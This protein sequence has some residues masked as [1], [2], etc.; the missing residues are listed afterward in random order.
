[1]LR[2]DTWWHVYLD[3][4]KQSGLA[5][6]E[7]RAATMGAALAF[8]S[9]FSLAPLLIIVIALAG[10]V[11]G[12]DAA[13]GAVVAQMAGLVGAPAAEAI[14]ALL[15]AAQ[16]SATSLFA[17]VV[18]LVMMLVGATTVLVELQDDL[19]QIWEAPRRAG[20]GLLSILRARILSLGMLLAIGFLLLV[21]LLFSGA[22]AAFGS[23]WEAY[24]PGAALILFHVSNNALS[25]GAITVLFAMLF[26]WLPN[27]TI[28]WK[29]VWVGALTTAVLFSAG[30]LAIGLYLGRTA[31]ASAYGAAGTLVVLLL[32]LYYSAQVF[33]LG[34][35][36]TR[37]HAE[38][39]RRKFVGSEPDAA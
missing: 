24:F 31:T 28:A 25:L 35:E 20:S 10:A 3:L 26:K 8:Y 11:F 27:V 29:D 32:W 13:R 17:T 38:H 2:A 22:M 12:A 37:I 33:L 39:R 18:G 36:F 15:K 16:G 19:D 23:Y 30:R 6:V 5:W 9:A 4:I 14:Q 34:A 21:S 1:M 7:D